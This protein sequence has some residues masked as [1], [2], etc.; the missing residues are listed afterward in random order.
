MSPF[1]ASQNMKG[2]EEVR[3]RFGAMRKPLAKVFGA[4]GASFSL[5][6]IQ[7]KEF[8]GKV[9]YSSLLNVL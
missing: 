3:T 8:N 6:Y 4:F 5:N 1:F 2:F 9:D 7:P